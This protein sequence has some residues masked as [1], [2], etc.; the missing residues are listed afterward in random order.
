M[1]G[2]AILMTSSCKLSVIMPGKETDRSKCVEINDMCV[3]VFIDS[4]LGIK[5]KSNLGL[6]SVNK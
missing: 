6:Y 1:F 2:T 4:R 5:N 3:E